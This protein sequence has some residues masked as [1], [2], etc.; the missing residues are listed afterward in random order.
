LKKFDDGVTKFVPDVPT[1]AVGPPSGTFVMPKSQA[2]NLIRQ[3]GGDVNKL[4][5]LI[6][7]ERGTLGSRPFRLDVKTRGIENAKW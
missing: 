1:G 7:L 3:A 2:D 6:G 4:E 5:D